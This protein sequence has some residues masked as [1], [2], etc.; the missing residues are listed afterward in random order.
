MGRLGRLNGVSKA[1]DCNW[2]ARPAKEGA[3]G[4]SG[5]GGGSVCHFKVREGDGSCCLLA[6]AAAALPLL[7]LSFDGSTQMQGVQ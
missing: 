6:A 4:K 7:I 1:M 3:V 2:A 5:K